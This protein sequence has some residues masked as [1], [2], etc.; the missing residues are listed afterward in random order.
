M[1]HVVA[2]RLGFWDVDQLVEAVPKKKLDRWMAVARIC[3]WGDE[4]S[5]A[6][7]VAVAVHN[8][9]TQFM[10]RA[11]FKPEDNELLR[12]DHFEPDIRTGRTPI[13][14]KPLTQEQ[15]EAQ[16]RSMAGF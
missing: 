6:S 4:W 3:G 11:G 7:T 5:M 9:M 8:Q 13:E 10:A 14:V 15:M 16:H 12:L 2:Q 1:L